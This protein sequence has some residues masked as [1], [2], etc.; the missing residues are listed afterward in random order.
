MS[1]ELW[2]NG[3][4]EVRLAAYMALR[5]LGASSDTSLL[6]MVLKVSR[7]AVLHALYFLPS[8]LGVISHNGSGS[9]HVQRSH[10]AF[11]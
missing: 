4:D 11:S 3:E 6:D 1:L 8:R 5:K 7:E 2:S 9:L 10:N